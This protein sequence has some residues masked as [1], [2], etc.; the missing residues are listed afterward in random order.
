ML[1]LF[2]ALMACLWN[3]MVMWF[4]RVIPLRVV[5]IAPFFSIIG[6]GEAVAGMAVQ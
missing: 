2:G 3:L 1:S 5:W 6:G 4:W